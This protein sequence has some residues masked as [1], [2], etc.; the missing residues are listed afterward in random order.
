MFNQPEVKQSVKIPLEIK[1]LI[2]TSE[3]IYIQVETGN[4]VFQVIKNGNGYC[5]IQGPNGKKIFYNFKN[6][7]NEELQDWLDNIC[8]KAYEV[9]E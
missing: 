6:H 9:I 3:G 4:I 2:R 5:W 1:R 8:K 7:T